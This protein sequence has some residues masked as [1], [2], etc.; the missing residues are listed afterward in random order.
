M[1]KAL[2]TRGISNPK[3]AKDSERIESVILHFAPYTLAGVGNVCAWASS[4][5]IGSCLNTA[6]RGRFDSTQAARI[7]RTRLF[8]RDRREFMGRLERELIAL[9]RRAERSGSLAVARLNGTSDIG[10]ESERTLGASIPERFPGI[11]FYDYTKSKARALRSVTDPRWP[12]NYALTL[13]R[14]E[15]WQSGEV[16]DMVARGVNVAVV[17]RGPELPTEFEGARVIDGTLSDWRFRDPRGVV[18]GLL[19]K[20]RAKADRSGF[21]VD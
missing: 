16:G 5:C 14:S 18:V 19:P 17:F 13:S 9:E 8:M 10:W 12:Q 2:L 1:A 4:G 6:G 11:V 20:G 15:T 3:T 21:V 7:E